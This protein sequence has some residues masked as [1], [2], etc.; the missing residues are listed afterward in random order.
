VGS[1]IGGDISRL[2]EELRTK[3]AEADK[4]HEEGK[5]ALMKAKASDDNAVWQSE[6][7]KAVKCFWD[8]QMIYGQVQDTLDE[9]GIDVPRAL[10]D[11]ISTNQQALVMARKTV[12]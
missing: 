4:L 5:A 9:R 6:A 7:K 2:P 8:A 1:G 3:L 10:V 12:P 11:K